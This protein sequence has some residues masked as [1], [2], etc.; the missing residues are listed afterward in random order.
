VPRTA[1]DR[2]LS[3]ETRAA[4][5]AGEDMQKVID[6]F[7]GVASFMDQPRSAQTQRIRTLIENSSMGRDLMARGFSQGFAEKVAKIERDNDSTR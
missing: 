1:S 4:K 2:A 7:K 3:P 6:S 5:L